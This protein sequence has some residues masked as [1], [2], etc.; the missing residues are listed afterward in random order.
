MDR[1][2]LPRSRVTKAT[3]RIVLP[4]GGYD[5]TQ[6]G[7]MLASVTVVAGRTTPFSQVSYCA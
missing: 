5:L 6:G 4:A 7:S 2:E 1:S 3:S